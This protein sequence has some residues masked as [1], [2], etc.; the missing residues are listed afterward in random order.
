MKKKVTLLVDAL[1]NLILGVL[2]LSFNPPLCRFLG[3]PYSELHFYPNILG[4]VFIGITIALVIEAYKK[5]ESP[6]TGLGLT[7]AVCINICGGTVLMLWLIFGNLPIPF[8]GLVLL[9][10]L[11]SALLIISITELIFGRGE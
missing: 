5:P 7:G 6:H 3:V 4:A 10:A 9:W 1:I 11:A 2:L 8:Q